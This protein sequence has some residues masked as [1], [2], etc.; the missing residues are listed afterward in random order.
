MIWW[1][2]LADT[3]KIWLNTL[4][5]SVAWYWKLIIMIGCS[6]FATLLI[7]PIPIADIS[8]IGVIE[9]RLNFWWYAL[10]I[11][12]IAFTDTV[13]AL[14]TYILS[15]KIIYYITKTK[16]FKNP[17]RQIR[18]DKRTEKFRNKLNRLEER[19]ANKKYADLT[20]FLA[21]A[22][23]LPYTMTIYA[24]ATLNYSKKKLV[25]ISFIS[26]LIK[27]TAVALLFVLGYKT[28]S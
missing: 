22:T 23:P 13:F 1:K 9:E 20:V 18:S 25:L 7:T 15:H 12:L 27:Y 16:K 17:K 19:I 8:F 10:N 5:R 26:R 24:A 4:L 14:L 21:G 2:A 11:I 28:F 3:I 6:F